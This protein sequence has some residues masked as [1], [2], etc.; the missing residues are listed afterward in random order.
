MKFFNRFIPWLSA[1]LL[2]VTLEIW[3]ARP[4]WV[5][6]CV[7]GFFIVYLYSLRALIENSFIHRIYWNYF[8]NPFCFLTSVFI[9]FVLIDNNIVRQLFVV[10]VAIGYGLVLQNIYSFIHQDKDYQPF[11]LENMYGY[12]NLTSLFLFSSSGFGFTMLLGLPSWIAL[13]PIFLLTGLL[14]YR[15]L[16]AHKIP[17]RCHWRYI[18]I[19]AALVAEAYYCFNLLPTSF[20]FNGLMVILVYYLASSIIRDLLIQVLNPENIKKYLYITFAITI[21]VFFTTRWY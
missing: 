14:F 13:L 2:I 15:T 10:V 16:L 6:Y 4:A 20:I 19:V 8:I 7:A 9:F 21:L 1:I 11:A 12:L 3:V 5:I 17:W 18:V